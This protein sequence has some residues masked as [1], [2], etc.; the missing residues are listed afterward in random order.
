M[1]LPC[2]AEYTASVLLITIYPMVDLSDVRSLLI[3]GTNGFVGRSLVEQIG[4]L[5]ESNLPGKLYLVT[6]RGLDF[7][8]PSKLLRITRVLQQDLTVEWN[9]ELQVSHIINLAADGSKF[10]YSIEANNTFTL[11][12]KNLISWIS[13]FRETPHLFHSSSGACY[14]Y[15]PID[16]IS[17]LTDP[18]S[19]FVRNRIQ[20]EDDLKRASEAFDFKLSI[21][22]LFTF[23]GVNLLNKDRYAIS[24]FIK[25]GVTSRNILVTGD[26]NTVRSYLHQNDMANWILAAILHP[27]SNTDLQI[28]SN[29]A[30]TIREL[31]EFVAENTSSNLSYSSNPTPGDIYLPNNQETR[32]KLQVTE[33]ENWKPAVL[34][35]INIVRMGNDAKL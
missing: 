2:D 32:A 19:S 1:E 11:I 29:K 8:L 12:V 30:V 10:P 26:P 13:T 6:R 25:S 23:S 28:G 3:T 18:K 24:H 35:M 16:T 21:G 22:R 7:N 33:G 9:L 17:G 31:A 20:A 5:D 27:D 15:K 4:K 14:G 34:E